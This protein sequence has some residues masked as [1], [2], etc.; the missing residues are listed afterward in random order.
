MHRSLQSVKKNGKFQSD[1]GWN[2]PIFSLQIDDCI[3]YTVDTLNRNVINFNPV[4]YLNSCIGKIR[5]KSQY[6]L[7]AEDQEAPRG[8]DTIT[9]LT[10]CGSYQVLAVDALSD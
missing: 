2:F 4:H 1:R 3:L 7:R 9:R 8:H 6:Y 5:D 10:R